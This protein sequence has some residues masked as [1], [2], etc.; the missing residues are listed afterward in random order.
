[1]SCTINIKENSVINGL[2]SILGKNNDLN[3][4]LVETTINGDKF[5][6]EFNKWV[7]DNYDKEL[8]FDT[9]DN[10]EETIKIMRDYHNYLQPDINYSTTIQNDATEVARFGYTST[11]ARETGKRIVV[12]K[13][14][15]IKHQL[16]HDYHEKPEGNK[17]VYFADAVTSVIEGI[18]VERISSKNNMTEDDIYDILDS[19]NAI[20]QLEN[21]FKDSTDQD[22]NVFALYKEILNNR[23][24]YF[25]QVFNDSRL[26]DIRFDKDDNFEDDDQAEEIA[27]QTTQDDTGSDSSNTNDD[28]DG[29]ERDNSINQLNN[30][31]GQYKDFMTHVG[32]SVRSYLGSLRK[33]NT[34]KM[35]D[36]K[37]DFDTSNEL[38][39]A[40]AMDI[41]QII[42]V[43][44]S[45]IDFTN[46]S[47]MIK[48]IEHIAK[49]IPGMEGLI[50]MSD[51]LKTNNDFAYEVYRTFAK[52]AIS[53]LETIAD[54]YTIKAIL[55]NRRADKLT[56][57]RFEY[58]N[59]VKSTSILLDDLSS[60]EIWESLNT[61]IND[62]QKNINAVNDAKE[63][64]NPDE[65]TQAIIYKIENEVDIKLNEIIN[66]LA[67]QF[68]RYYPTIES[69]FISN[70]I[71]DNNNGD[72]LANLKNLNTIL[73]NT[74]NAAYKT[75][76]NYYSQQAELRKAYAHNKAL[77]E[78]KNN[79][80]TVKKSDYIDLTPYYNNDYIDSSTQDAAFALADELVKYSPVKVELNSRNVHGNLSSDIINNSMI[81]NIMNT[82]KSTIA[83]KNFGKYKSQSRQYDFSNIMIEHKDENGKIINYGLFTIDEA[84][85]EF[86][87]TSYAKDLLKANLF[88]GASDMTSSKNV[89]YSEMSKGD[90]IATSF[91]NFFKTETKYNITEESKQITFA[92]YFMRIPSDAPKNFVM[93]AP[94][95]STKETDYGKNDGLFIVNNP[96]E[97]DIEINKRINALTSLDDSYV[98]D[99][100]VCINRTLYQ[101]VSNITANTIGDIIIPNKAFI[102]EKGAKQGDIITVNFKY[103]NDDKLVTQYVLEGTL[104]KKDGKLVLEKPSFQG[105][106]GTTRAS[107]L[108]RALEKHYK[109]ELIKKGVITRTI[110]TAHPIYR[111]LHN[112]FTQEIT[113]AATAINHIF[114]C[115][116]NGKIVLEDN[117]KPKFKNGFAD[118]EKTIRHL[119]STYHSNG[120]HIIENGQFT[121]KVFHSDRFTISKID[122]NGKAI[123]RN[124]GEE[125]IKEAFDFLYGGAKDTYIHFVNTAK[126]VKISFTEAQEAKIQ[127]KLTSFINDYI[128]DTQT[129]L[130]PF[131]EFI[132]KG[133]NNEDNIIEFALNYYLQYVNFNDLFEGDTK[134]YKDSQTFLKRAKE[135]QGS[136]V[137]YGIVNYEEA[138][139]SKKTPITHRLNTP[140]FT[141]IKPDGTKEQVTVGFYNRFNAV[142][143]K[144]TIR[145]SKEA[146][147]KGL[148]GA[149][150]DGILVQQLTDIFKKQNI[151]EEKALEAARTMMSGYQETTVNDAQSYITFEEWIRR[152]TARGQ[153]GKYK[154]LID[155]IYDESKPVNASIINE[156][157][158]VQKNFYYDQYYSKELGVVVPRQIKNAEFVLVP[159]FIKGTQLEQV[160]NLMKDNDIDQLNT[161]ETSKAGKANVLTIWDNDGNITKE[162]I[163][164]FNSNVE[165]AKELFNYNYLYTQQE[166]PQH[167]NDKNKAAIQIM[168][169]IVDNIPPTSN[170]Y[171][172]KQKFNK[173]YVSNIK[174]SFKDLMRELNLNLDE[175]GNLKLDEHGNI[176]GLDYELF[177]DKLKSEVVRLGLDSN[178]IDYITLVKDQITDTSGN[179]SLPIT[180]MPTFMSIV[181]SKLESV[182]QSVFN[183]RVTR[184]TL[185]GFHA[186][187]ITNIGF[188][189]NSDNKIVYKLKDS[190]KGKGFKDTLT[191][192]EYNKLPIKNKMYYVKTKGNIATSKELHYH[193]N[194]E[195]YIEVLL[196]KS[197]F[198]FYKDNNGNYTKSDEELLKELQDAGLDK[199]IGYRI[200][201]EG[202]QSVAIMK[203]VGFTD[204]AL[205]STIV[206][207]DDWVSQ[208]GSDFDID[209]VYGIQFNSEIDFITKKIKKV[210]YVTD[211]TEQ[212]YFNYLRS[213]LKHI[214]TK[215]GKKIDAL[216][217]AIE[218]DRN[219]Q[220]HKLLDKEGE[221][222]HALPDNIREEIKRL[223]NIN[224]NKDKKKDNYE[225]QNNNVINGLNKYIEE[226]D[227]SEEE[228]D[229]IQEYIKLRGQINDFIN[230]STKEDQSKFNE[231]KSKILTER[232]KTIED[233]A[234]TNNLPTYN[235]FI[236]LSE[237]DRNT[238]ES[239]NNELLKCMLDILSNDESLEENLSRSNFDDLIDSRDA[240]IDPNIKT[241]RDNRSPYNFLDQADYQEDVM[242]GAK[243]KAF[244][245]TRDTFVSVCNTVR[246]YISDKN[247]ITIQYYKKDGYD[248]NILEN[249]FD[250]VEVFNKGKEDEYYVVKHNT[251]GWSKNNKNVANKILTSYSSQTTAHILD[252]V[253]KGNIPN[254][255]DFTFAV[256]KCFPDIGSDYKTCVSFIMQPGVKY[257][258]DAYNSS[259]SIYSI[260][261]AKPFN[262]AFKNIAEQIFKLKG[263]E[264]N[265]KDDIDTIIK[266]LQPFNSSLALLFGTTNTN[267]KISIDP[268]DANDLIISSS[269][270]KDRLN[271][272]GIFKGNSPVEEMNRLLFDLGVLL[273]YNRLSVLANSIG[274]YARVC[275]PDKFG[276]KQT[277]FA[278]NEIFDKI[279][280]IESRDTQVLYVKED[281]NIPIKTFL[282]SI[283][284]DI[285][286]GIDA[287]I[288]STNTNSSYPS[289][290][291]FLKYAT[292]VSIKI[293]R[294]LFETQSEAFRDQVNRLRIA[295]T[296]DKRMT[297]KIYKDFQNYI[298]NYLY[299]QT[300][301]VSK[302]LIWTGDS[303]DYKE[304]TDLN[305]ERSRIYGYGKTVDLRV[306]DDEGNMV[307]FTVK[308]I[309]NPTEKEIN[310]FL[311]F[312][313]AQKIT[314]IQGNFVNSRLFSYIKTTLYNEREYRKNKAGSQT[315]EFVDSNANIEAIYD[316]FNK[317]FFNSNP[318]I[319]AAAFDI[320]KYAFAVEGFKMKRNGVSK[321]ISND[322][323]KINEDVPN[324]NIVK[325]LM[326]SISNISSNTI[327]INNLINNFVRSHSNIPQI[328]IKNVE[329]LDKKVYEL[330]RNS[331]GIISLDTNN[332]KDFELAD[333]YKF[334]YKDE[335]EKTV[336][337]NKYVKLRFGKRTELYKIR[338]QGTK[339]IAYPLSK[340]EENENSKWS[341]NTQ[342]NNGYYDEEFYNAIIDEWFGT[343]ANDITF[344]TI[345]GKYDDKASDHKVK[346]ENNINKS[347]L[348]KDFNIND[349]DTNY[350]GGFE[351]VIS[352]V[353][354]YFSENSD[355][356]LY[357]RSGALAKFITHTGIINGSTQTINGKQYDIQKVDFK[358][359]NRAYISGKEAI[360]REIKEKDPQIVDIIERA[361]QTGYT[362]NDVFKITPHNDNTIIVDENNEDENVEPNTLFNSSITELGVGSMKAMRRRAI[363]ENDIEASK[364]LN[365]LKD[366]AITA[367]ENS[368]KMNL[369]E[370]VPVTAE[371][372]K[373]TVDKILNDLKY[374]VMDEEGNYHSIT[375][376]YTINYIKNN[377]EER[378]RF[379]KTLL[380]AR[381][382][383]RNY[384]IINELDISSEDESLRSNLNKIKQSIDNIQNSTIINQAEELFAK[385]CI[386]KLSDNPAI[387]SDYISILDGY[388]SAGAFDAWVND[389]QETSNPLLQIITK[390][391]M[392]D[393]RS[394]ELLANKRVK[395]FKTALNKIKEEAKKA[396][397]NIDY[398][399]IIDD[400][401]KFIQDYNQAFIDKIEELRS[402]MSNAKIEFGDGSL[403]Y[404]KAKFE[405]DKFKLN[406]VN[407]R[408]KDEYYQTKLT[409]EK[410][411]IDHFPVIYSEYNKLISKR[412]QILSHAVNGVLDENYQ[413]QLHKIKKDIDALTN[414][415]EY[416]YDIEGFGPKYSVDDPNN[417]YKDKK[418]RIL[419]SME[420]AIALNKFLSNMKEL[421]NNYFVKDAKFGFDEEL[422]KNLDIISN[423]EQRDAN[424]RITVPVVELMKHDD[425]VKAKDWINQNARYVI[426][427]EVKK[428]IDDA[429]SVFRENKKGGNILTSTAKLREAYD[430]NGIIN[431]TKFTDE[432]LDNLR[433]ETL[434]RYNIKEGQAFSDKLLISNTPANDV[435]FKDSFYSGMKSN[436]IPNSKYLEYVNKINS[437]LI[438]YYEQGTKILH[439][440]EISEED[441][442]KLDK[443]YDDIEDIKKTTNS[444]NGK[445][446]K[447]YIDNNVDFITN[448]E[449]YNEQKGLASLKGTRYLLKWQSVFERVEQNK[450]NEYIVVPNR[451]VF[452]YA[453]PKG[454]KADGTGDNSMVDKKK[455]NA[456]HIIQNYTTKTKTK[457]YFDKY[458]EMRA[459]KDEEFNTWF[460]KNHVYNPYS[461]NYEPLDCWTHLEIVPMADDGRFETIGEWIPNYN[462]RQSRPFDGKDKNGKPDGSIDVL[463]HDY[464]ENTTLANN[465]K[466]K[467]RKLDEE[468][469]YIGNENELKDDTNYV[470]TNNLNEYERKVRDLFKSTLYQYAN[471][472]A[473]KKYI[474]QGFMAS[475]RKEENIDKNFLA[476]EAA[477]FVGWIDT[478]TGKEA[479]Y[480]DIDYAK[481]KTIDMPLMYILKS[482]DSININY[483]KPKQEEN[484]SIENYTKRLQEYNNKR[485]ADE[486]T[487][488]EIHKNLLDTNWED[489]M[490]DYI[491]KAMHFNAIQDNKYMLFYAKNMLD[492]L[493]VY[494]KNEGFNNLQKDAAL[495][496]DE[497]TKY[498]TRKDTRLQEQYVNWIRRLV[499]DQWKK[500]NNK[501]TRVANLMQSLTS[502]KFMMLNITG[503]IAN[504]TAGETQILGEV[505]AKQYFGT[506]LWAKGISTWN[507]GLPSFLADMHSDKTSSVQSALV[508][509]FNIVDFDEYTGVIHVNNLNKKLE[510]IRDFTY[511]PQSTGEHF[512]QNSALFSMM[513][514]HR[515]C[516]NKDSKIN[517]RLSYTVK[518]EAEFMRDA[519]E[520][521]LLSILDTDDI[522]EK[523]RK[524]KEIEFKDPN[525]KKEYAW[526]RKNIVSDFVNTLDNTY[527]TKFVEARRE[528]QKQAKKEFN[529]DELHPT[530]Y[531]QFELDA[532]STLAFKD[533]SIL[534]QMGEDAYQLLGRFKNR[535]IS[536]NKK[537]HGVYDRL[538]AAKWESYWW[539]GIVMQYHKHIYPGI[540]KR[541]RR[542]GYFNEERGT[543]E[544]GCYASIKDFLALPLRKQ[545]FINK[546]KAENDINDDNIQA[547]LGIQNVI[548]DYVDFVLHIRTN[549]NIIPEYDRANIKRAL[550][551]VMGVMSALCT[552]ISLQI[553]AGGDDKEHSILYNLFMYESDRLASE[554]A[555]YTIPGLMSEGAKLWSS[556]VAVESG[557]SDVL[558]SAGLIAQYMIQGEDFDPYYQ[559]G[560]YA[561][562]N[563]LEV[564]LK[565]QIPMYHGIDMVYRLQ[566]SNKYYKLDKNMLSVIPIG[567]IADWVR[568]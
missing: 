402:N 291:A 468:H 529:N 367:T 26:G 559:T 219:E 289:L 49:T 210:K 17:K 406:H 21:I 228:F 293:N 173:L 566:R 211:V 374:F 183:N 261:Y 207:P 401:G 130:E 137:P 19:E 6:D 282:S 394:K 203:V 64:E 77:D 391:V 189:A 444:T 163:K 265:K 243:L 532:N 490:E 433:N 56:S 280:E 325:E 453:V 96:Q 415:L 138:L 37:Y 420:S 542:Q 272:T 50:Q 430:N 320:V 164:D 303:F 340:L 505:F 87:P 184:Q 555:M 220:F 403:E 225:A 239:R 249:S 538:G 199:I 78:I 556:P 112:I 498:V 487:N 297:E 62:Y 259:K 9:T 266:K 425:Y 277:I 307:E 429:F 190:G 105:F 139:D 321:I 111:Q 396:G 80:G 191:E 541:Y 428:F 107:E 177:F 2:K 245:V 338:M 399:H 480:E 229:K 437:I 178:M 276:A 213:K 563:K 382:F 238:T 176:K 479:W 422:E 187:Q 146:A 460:Y 8:D 116:E 464:I 11:N 200:P 76:L 521:A 40:E 47:D 462:Q 553:I 473:A 271:N 52:I 526:F 461:H 489:V 35:I 376:N 305:K 223:Q 294:Q 507:Q 432:D 278:T 354:K 260:S 454:Y 459:K 4:I 341:V 149:K 168:K 85:Q 257:L 161:E 381:A 242:S 194:K 188:K 230:N 304:D 197:N 275:N 359:Y 91:I 470:N 60:K 408:I 421:R 378:N 97:A 389:L 38:G 384:R 531:S 264:F 101:A 32:M 476:K 273:Q 483:S 171:P 59:S 419:K 30:K 405:Y 284:P 567:D 39:I 221:L 326:R 128:A 253:K 118:D 290:N 148:N 16:E 108:V 235:E 292:A 263:I 295:F 458:K 66:E 13:L 160:Y 67:H 86:I 201:T 318:L 154:P 31:D 336:Y 202:K 365:R 360:Y 548:K 102:N 445:A 114:T 385:D 90:Y 288:T 511:S 72:V 520:K 7:K 5:N 523:Y 248:L 388:H 456:M 506:K 231:E 123:V 435:I 543:I 467:G 528:Y 24:E 159:R 562:E 549:W 527:K 339:L 558:S 299:N 268:S 54:T 334:I 533:D 482:K 23:E 226:Q 496:T 348:A 525:S 279:Q 452:G 414:T 366:K 122:E 493:R 217:K 269:K 153:L 475:R 20:E 358:K 236:K 330:Y 286:K 12:D 547:A 561:G 494:V 246:P 568:K 61:A 147:V 438:K 310:Q 106:A 515:L 448:D 237:E 285:D 492:K 411:M 84:S 469:I 436:G 36:D 309:N 151:S 88:S 251:F 346:Y 497:E 214:P 250:N 22:K 287:F 89:L 193:P 451:R 518:N 283:Y 215:V 48:S 267:Y 418:I 530:L 29:T 136:G 93:I 441:L 508:K 57:L 447:A 192:E 1:M 198:G 232:L 465:F 328:A 42:T 446:I 524:Y 166:T 345:L 512:M 252:A 514:S 69:S 335:S 557:I 132:N 117:G 434:A 99:D 327:D 368:V 361:R 172:I 410:D 224:N 70:Y 162:N 564:K 439:T 234:K 343:S 379:L 73:K 516:V 110:N 539:G 274:E 205:G 94:R 152:I 306:P 82:L 244:S 551:D 143:I 68:K 431:G 206:V 537:I 463:N 104:G 209:S 449:L 329:L 27:T 240:I 129:R 352:K 472:A 407:Q 141:H 125:I 144:N 502:A 46:V 417:P 255:N 442:E 186:A 51:Y 536:V 412:D 371:Y 377:K 113:D 131:N 270:Y 357:L 322:V 356:K 488:L 397:V 504:V 369:D 413:E 134:F 426:T 517:G 83:L 540:M 195:K 298:I 363:S 375:D 165:G 58:L 167:V 55:S 315:I 337:S 312:S 158:Q 383:V 247:T 390:E 15:N 546:L 155:A 140:L 509:F 404:L 98:I 100:D 550:G 28:N 121:G 81:T 544:K 351:D 34:T 216:K 43:L 109:Q 503:G 535:V 103:V 398:S 308:N 33:C 416:H 324:T 380:D 409:L 127:E 227:L 208:T 392:G 135:A 364:A 323:L 395:D 156:F 316:D 18:I 185:P 331:Y 254:V 212:A 474:N 157:V 142:T 400:Y 14:L 478:A 522:K 296:D 466:P 499:Y 484:E 317:A 281:P 218:N 332:K 120:K 552:A 545:S 241:I 25:K 204:D 347:L 370:V 485:K 311:T 342:N 145:T 65:E 182:A 300:N 262:L 355:G 350:T 423:Y 495:S 95:Y 10:V 181:S 443:L 126:G 53:K 362:V 179:L 387:Q 150:E 477:K 256:Y 79:G 314:W 440:D 196:P 424:G 45:N 313:P 455:T 560:L 519:E 344:N 115:A 302:Q 349:K 491:T 471:T 180:V 133:L 481:D 450:D 74:I 63:I 301:A 353:N 513:Y 233:I 373:G 169:K 333:K 124:Y 44:Y 554:S 170:L 510:H 119:Y 71:K 3:T 319:A 393:I 75:Q 486:A 174:T 41:N 501:L 372:V 457:Y 386:A 92:N 427:P 258:V 534:S 175:N 222:Y 500:P 565:R